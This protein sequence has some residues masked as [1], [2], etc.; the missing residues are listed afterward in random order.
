MA[1]KK[2]REGMSKTHQ[3]KSTS[4]PGSSSL[5]LPHSFIDFLSLSLASTVS[6]LPAA[7]A[8]S[9]IKYGCLIY[10]QHC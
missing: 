1:G 5:L 4:L 10:L 7:P 2:G 6:L 3:S 9:T 8:S